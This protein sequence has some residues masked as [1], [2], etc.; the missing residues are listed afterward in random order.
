MKKLFTL[1]AVAALAFAANAA[2]LTVCDGE[3]QS[4]GNP[5]Y[6][7]WFDTEG[8]TQQIYPAEMLADMNGGE[9]T[10]ITFTTIGAAYEAMGYTYDEVY[11]ADYRYYINFDG[12]EVVLSL[13]EINELGF[14]EAVAFEGA[15]LVATADPVK[16]TSELMI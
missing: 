3:Y 4:T 1:F 13:M 9:I 16:G 14:E 11:D 5:V 10:E 15:T 2:V 6:G 8:I 7:L 12:A